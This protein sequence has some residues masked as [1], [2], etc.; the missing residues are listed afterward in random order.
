M[1][2]RRP[3]KSSG[4]REPATSLPT[5]PARSSC[6]AC[7][8]S[9]DSLGAL[10]HRRGEDKV[11]QLAVLGVEDALLGPLPP[12]AAVV[13]VDDL[14]ADLHHGVHVV[15]VDDRRDVV[16]L[17][18]LVDQVVDD[19]R[20][21]RV[22]ARVGFVA[23]QVAWIEHDGP[24]DG[25]ALDHAARQLGRVEAVGV[26]EPHALQAEV[27][28]LHLLALAL[29][30]EEVER[31]LDILLD[32]RGVEQRPALEDHA[33]VLADGLALAEAQRREV[34]VVVPHVAR[35]GFVQPDERLEQHGL[36]RAAASDDEIRLAGL[37]L[38]RDVVEHDP[39][40]E[41]LDDVFGTYHISST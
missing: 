25:H 38:D 5:G 10:G 23:E 14:L 27:H 21:L 4:C 37:E 33:D 36:A 35:V 28:A 19:D 6:S 17:R 13:D 30:G 22:E 39:A 29:R 18:D 2:C 8:R 7:F 3:E 15:R 24:R 40:V 34:H 11:V 31:Q 20:G 16:L 32:G 41:R 12:L 9:F 1:F 26:L